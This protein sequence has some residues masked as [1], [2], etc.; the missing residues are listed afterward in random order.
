MD[1]EDYWQNHQ[2]INTVQDTLPT[3]E[4][5]PDY[6]SNPEPDYSQSL[7]D[8]QNG[9]WYDQTSPYQTEDYSSY[10]SGQ[11]NWHESGE[12]QFGNQYNSNPEQHYSQSVDNNQDGNWYDQT[13][14]YQAADY[15]SYPSGQGENWYEPSE[16]QFGNQGENWAD[17]HSPYAE[18]HQDNHYQQTDHY[19]PD[20]YQ[21]SHDDVRFGSAYGSPTDLEQLKQSVVE[22]YQE[23]AK[24]A[25][26]EQLSREQWADDE[27]SAAQDTEAE[28]NRMD[29][30][31]ALN[32]HYYKEALA[33]GINYDPRSTT[34]VMDA[35]MR[36]WWGADVHIHKR[37]ALEYEMAASSYGYDADRYQAKA[38]EYAQMDASYFTE[39]RAAQL[40]SEPLKTHFTY[41][42]SW[43]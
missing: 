11:E 27:R 21:D 12:T 38:R 36:G 37:K 29:G 20:R 24:E 5:E 2:D 33:H 28:L 23:L 30:K 43:Q 3:F 16:T 9:N 40:T 32:E 26:N 25:H 13:S 17:N 34:G 39:E 22:H 35:A 8:N 6:N 14:A 18:S 42:R 41:D 4:T 7:D 19:S 10:P 15:S 1:T 31:E